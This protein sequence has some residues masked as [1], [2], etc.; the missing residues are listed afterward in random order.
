M[1][2]ECLNAEPNLSAT[3]ILQIEVLTPLSMVVQMPGKYYR[4]QAE[5]SH[6]ML[7]GLME[8]ALGWHFSTS[9][10]DKILKALQ[11]KHKLLAP[12][13]ASGS[14]YKSI[15]Q[16]HL[17]F[18]LGVN[19]PADTLTRFDDYW[20]QH[21][22]TGGLEFVGGSR[23]YDQR[24][25]P[26]M[27]AYTDKNSGVTFTDSGGTRDEKVFDQFQS[28][29]KINL[30]A[31]RPYFPRYYSSPTSRE[32]VIPTMA[33]IYRVETSAEI[34]RML[35]DAL[36]DPVAPLYLGSNDGWVEAYWQNCREVENA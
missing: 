32:Y 6:Q 12:P 4:S 30:A 22:R 8:N 25:I 35:E 24:L 28:G 7:F 5:P 29:D 36:R 1:N 17:R 18:G 2:L 26:L 19:M 21:L 9:D 11:I 14:G 20:S 13:I 27:N 33:Y 31:V 15:L 10:Q 16:Y 34:A 23:G 3:A